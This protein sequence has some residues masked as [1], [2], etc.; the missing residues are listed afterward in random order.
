MGLQDSGS[1]LILSPMGLPWYSARD[2][3]QTL[4][5][6]QAIQNNRQNL[7]R[8]IGGVLVNIT[9]TEFLKYGSKISSSDQQPPSVDG[10]WP[11]TL[12]TVTCITQLAYPVGGSPQRPVFSGSTVTSNGFVFYRPILNMMITGWSQSFAEWKAGVHWELDLEEV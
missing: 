3:T 11:G 2:I 5:P 7:R 10:V 6:I 8:T 9:P 12:V 1:L 4:N